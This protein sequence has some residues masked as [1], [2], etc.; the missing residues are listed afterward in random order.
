[1]SAWSQSDTIELVCSKKWQETA[2]TVSFQLSHPTEEVQFDFKPGQFAT[3]G[4]RVEGRDEYRAYSMSSMPKQSHLQFT[5]KR[6]EEG[7]VS[8]HVVDQLIVG[9]RVTVF[10]PQGRFNSED[11]K[12]H[13]NKV[14]L[15]SAGCGITPVMSMV[16][17]W[18]SPAFFR[19]H[20][21][22]DRVDIE[23]IHIARDM[24]STIY[25]QQLLDLDAEYSNFHLKLLLKQ[26]SGERHPQGR[27]D[28]QWLLTLCP[29]LLDRTLFLCG[30]VA[31]M[32]DVASYLDQINFNMDNFYQESFT[33]IG[34]HSVDNVSADEGRAVSAHPLVISIPAFAAQIE[35]VSG[36]LLV[37]ALEKANLPIIAACRSG[38]CGSCRCKVTSGIVISSSQETLSADDIEQGYVLSCS[39]QVMSDVE[40]SLA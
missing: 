21:M 15:V 31:F 2:D 27:L 17:Q 26:S 36:S 30:P 34:S 22:E 12:A 11:C 35:A 33:P 3:L 39:T 9:E 32:Q 18:L 13:S 29:D 28:K 16:K 38:L 6:V 40:V 5:V 20:K 25:Y 1:M 37:D 14:V 10:K 8:N 19:N 7:K 24:A 23:F 4:F